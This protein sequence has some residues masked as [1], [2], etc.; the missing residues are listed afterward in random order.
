MS[1]LSSGS[2]A[3]L[4]ATRSAIPIE[5]IGSVASG[6]CGPCGLVEPTGQMSTEARGESRIPWIRD[7]RQVGEEEFAHA[8]SAG[9]TATV[10]R[11]V[12]QSAPAAS[13]KL[14]SHTHVVRPR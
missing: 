3:S 8:V 12:A 4:R 2:S 10:I 5:M 7:V 9:R 14:T 1:T 6:E 13:V 11:D